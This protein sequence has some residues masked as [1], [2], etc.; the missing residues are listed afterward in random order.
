MSTPP[1]EGPSYAEL[2]AEFQAQRQLIQ[3]QQ[4]L[5]AELQEQV[6]ELTARLNQNSSNSSRPPST[7]PP[8]AQ[9]RP[10]PPTGRKR[11]GQPGHRG[12]TRCSFPRERVD[13]H[14]EHFPAACSHCGTALGPAAAGEGCVPPRCHQVVELPPLRPVVT[15]HHLHRDTCAVCGKHTWATLPSGVPPRVVGPRLQAVIGLLSGACRLS[16]RTVQALLADLFEVRLSLGTLCAVEAD[17][18]RALAVPYQ[19]VAAAVARA[20]AVHVDET[21]WREA[22]KRCWIWTAT[23]GPLALFRLDRRNQ[24]ACDALLTADG[25]QPKVTATVISDR[26]GA[27]AHLPRSQR[28]LCWAHL[29]RDFRGLTESGGASVAVGRWALEVIGKLFG[30]WRRCQRGE[31]DRRGLAE[32]V[33]P[34]QT[35]FRTLLHWGEEGGCRKGQALCRDLLKHWEALWTWV[36]QE[37]VAPTNNAA[38]R[39]LRPAVL[40]RKSSF[41]HQSESGKAFVERLLTTVTSLR[42]QRRTVWSYLEAV[43]RASLDGSTPPSL[44]PSP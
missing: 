9:R 4:A 42:L 18:T 3:Q 38:E 17:I 33:A 1:P 29:A 24:A 31:L 8:G 35:Q 20:P 7:D 22:G 15:E 30:E 39:A 19:E 13:H 37:G 6:R 5:I 2:W 40:W 36:H 27:Y 16:R 44:L 10:K 23:A 11:G 34:L 41:G 25:T 32:A 43:C 12:T 14:E 21:G 28:S 26:Y